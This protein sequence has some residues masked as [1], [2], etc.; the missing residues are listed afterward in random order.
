MK[1]SRELKILLLF[2]TAL[3]I[4]SFRNSNE[5][6]VNSDDVCSLENQCFVS[7]E[8]LVFKV[9]YNWKFIWVPAGQARFRIVETDSL[10]IVDVK[11]TSYSSYDSF[12]KVRDRY[13]S[14]IDKNTLLP[15]SFLRDISQGDYIRYDSMVINQ[16][17][18]SIT[19]YYGKSKE[20]AKPHEFQLDRCTQDLVSVLYHLRN[21]DIS[22]IQKGSKLPVSFFF[23]K[24]QYNLDVNIIDRKKRKIK[25]LGKFNVIH[26]RPE[27]IT[28]SVFDENS[29]MDVFVSDDGNKVPLLV[30]SPLRVGSAKAVLLSHKNLKY[31]LKP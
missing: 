14:V 24:K 18:Y 1:S 30:E 26:A 17:D 10:F 19:E 31:E 27:L 28:G 16:T 20:K 9:Y 13:R 7:G 15:K 6:V 29:Y 12:F 3:V 25:G 11:G 2:F 22:N 5:H 21:R 4:L 8:E 23:S